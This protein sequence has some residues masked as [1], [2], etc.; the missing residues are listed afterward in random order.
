MGCLCEVKTADR[1]TKFMALLA[2]VGAIALFSSPDYFKDHQAATQVI[3]YAAIA[4]LVLTLVTLHQGWVTR[5]HDQLHPLL[6]EQG[7]FTGAVENRE[8]F[9]LCDMCK[10]AGRWLVV[11][12]GLSIVVIVKAGLILEST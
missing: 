12:W 3:Q 10:W 11:N 9:S 7:Q 8:R 5:D 6:D 4:I 2:A 1:I